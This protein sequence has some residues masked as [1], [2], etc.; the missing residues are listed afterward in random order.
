M[1]ESGRFRSDLYYR[2]AGVEI[3]VPPLRARKEDIA[4]LVE[5]FVARY[6]RSPPISMSAGAMEALVA[7]HWPGNVRQL[8]RT[9][10]RAIALAPGPLVTV[11]DLPDD[12]SKDY[13]DLDAPVEDRDDTLRAWSSRYVRLVLDRCDGNKRRACDVL[14]I[15]YH[16]LK[17]HLA[18]DARRL[19]PARQARRATVVRLNE[20]SSG[21]A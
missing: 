20:A 18:Y 6:R 15:S 21:A 8:E 17:S 12:I 7:F 5:H 2:L 9:V 3:C 19:S 11:A 13:G 16:T 1:V 10:E 14:D 4:S